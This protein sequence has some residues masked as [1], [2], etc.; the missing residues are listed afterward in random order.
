MKFV[1]LKNGQTAAVDSLLDW[2]NDR[3]AHLRHLNRT[4]HSFSEIEAM[5]LHGRMVELLII[6]EKVLDG[7]IQGIGFKGEFQEG[8]L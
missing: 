1:Q 6:R 7:R 4:K 5:E 2:V 8:A 3:L